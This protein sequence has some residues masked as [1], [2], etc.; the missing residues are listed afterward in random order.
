MHHCNKTIDELIQV[1]K[2]VFQTTE[3]KNDTDN[4]FS[5]LESIF[6]TLR[7]CI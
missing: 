1:G 2:L 4:H 6:T 5:Q 7:I 3:A